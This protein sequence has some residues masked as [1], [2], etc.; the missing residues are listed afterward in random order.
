MIVSILIHFVCKSKEISGWKCVANFRQEVT[1]RNFWCS[2]AAASVQRH[3]GRRKFPASIRVKLYPL[4][5]GGGLFFS[6]DFLLVKQRKN[7]E[8]VINELSG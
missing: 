7:G 6:V 4:Y 3:G 2:W 8:T 5:I 1:R